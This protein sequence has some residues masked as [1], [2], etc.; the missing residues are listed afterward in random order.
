MPVPSRVA[1]VIGSALALVVLASCATPTPHSKGVAPVPLHARLLTEADLASGGWIPAELLP[2]HPIVADVNPT[3]TPCDGNYSEE[4]GTNFERTLASRAFVNDGSVLRESIISGV[5]SSAFVALT[6]TVDECDGV[7]GATTV[8]GIP[9]DVIST[10][11]DLGLPSDAIAVTVLAASEFE[12]SISV[13]MYAR[14]PHDTLLIVSILHPNLR[15]PQIAALLEQALGK[16]R[17][18]RP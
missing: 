14:A 2:D 7:A 10:R 9:T 11:L 5:D 8:N 4:L 17:G 16:A 13:W 18:I 1:A 12:G 6:D 15:T 3:E